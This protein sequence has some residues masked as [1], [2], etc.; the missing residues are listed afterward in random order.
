[1]KLNFNFFAK[2]CLAVMTGVVVCALK[3]A[4]PAAV[5]SAKSAFDSVIDDYRQSDLRGEGIP[6]DAARR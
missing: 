3:G 1:M 5:Q 4:E 2:L 6:L